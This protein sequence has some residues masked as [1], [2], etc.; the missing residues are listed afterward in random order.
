MLVSH[1]IETQ[2]S[3]SL[4]CGTTLRDV[5]LGAALFSPTFGLVLTGFCCSDS[6]EDFAVVICDIGG[7]FINTPMREGE[8]QISRV[9]QSRSHD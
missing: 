6:A 1:E 9:G 7:V 5:S 4:C 8:H 2:A 3:A